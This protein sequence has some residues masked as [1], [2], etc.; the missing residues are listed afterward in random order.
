MRYFRFFPLRVYDLQGFIHACKVWAL[1]ATS[2]FRAS[3]VKLGNSYA[4][5]SNGVPLGEM[6]IC[7]KLGATSFGDGSQDIWRV[8]RV[9]WDHLL[10]S[11]AEIIQ[12][13][14]SFEFL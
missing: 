4:S 3:F 13:E 12:K 5:E 14:A 7:S 11:K 9:I 1:F 8:Q 10:V 2:P 6:I